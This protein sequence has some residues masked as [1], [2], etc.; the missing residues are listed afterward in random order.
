M[1]VL[2]VWGIALVGQVCLDRSRQPRLSHQWSA[3][4][5]DGRAAR[6]GAREPPPPHTGHTRLDLAVVLHIPNDLHH[7]CIAPLP[8]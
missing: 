2:G 7:F 8:Q 5:G 1:F 3:A 4:G 6:H